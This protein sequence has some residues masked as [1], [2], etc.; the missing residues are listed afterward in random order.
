[1]DSL[2]IRTV[3]SPSFI[4]KGKKGKYMEGR[5]H[6]RIDLLIFEVA[7]GGGGVGEMVKMMM[8]MMTT[9]TMIIHFSTLSTVKSYICCLSKHVLVIPDTTHGI[10]SES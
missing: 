10:L 7:G 6:W 4:K 3:F 5:G 9:T 1:M 8:M 2:H